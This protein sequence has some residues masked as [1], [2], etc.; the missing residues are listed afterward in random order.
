MCTCTLQCTVIRPT[1]E[2]FSVEVSING[3]GREIFKDTLLSYSFSSET[4]V[5]DGHLR[6]PLT[7]TP[8]VKRLAVELSLPVLRLYR[9]EFKHPTFRM[10]G[11][12]L[13]DCATSA[14]VWF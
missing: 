1:R 9:L 7:L 2:F 13:T 10:R 12:A 3:A 11:N 5:N 4:S 14:A 8:V 6:G